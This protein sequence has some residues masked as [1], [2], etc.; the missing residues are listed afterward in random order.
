MTRKAKQTIFNGFLPTLLSR[1]I[2]H[3]SMGVGVLL[4]DLVT[5]PLLMF[6][7]LFVI[8]V[9]LSAWLSSMRLAYVLAVGLPFGRFLIAAFV[10][11]PSIIAIDAINGAIRCLVLAFLVFLVGR[12]SH[13]TREIG[14]LKQLLPTCM[15]CSR[16]RDE[17]DN[18]QHMESYIAEHSGVNFSHG[19]CPE[20][21]KKHYSE[22]LDSS[23]GQLAN[24]EGRV[25]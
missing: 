4:M 3:V 1:Q 20:C 6:P 22:F 24:A 17:R 12:I 14:R 7:I 13:Q 19:L 23:P 15:H 25:L 2:T 21:A 5:G 16:I 8:P 10:E 9:V 18:W 11:Q